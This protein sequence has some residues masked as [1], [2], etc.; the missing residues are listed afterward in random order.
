MKARFFLLA[1]MLAFT[2]G[3]GLAAAATMRSPDISEIMN[4]GHNAKTG[5]IVQLRNEMKKGS[6]DWKTVQDTSSEFVKLAEGLPANDPPK[7]SKDSW[8]KLCDTYVKTVK[9]L[10]AAAQKKNKSGCDAALAKL[11]KSCGG[12]HSQHKGS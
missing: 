7:G 12:C 11:G 9:D 2:C 1:G 6:P 8:K 10:D 4:K 5:F 3:F